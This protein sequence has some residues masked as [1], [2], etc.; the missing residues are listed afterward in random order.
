M[1]IL[2]IYKKYK[3]PHHLQLHILRVGAVATLIIDNI[4]H[5]LVTEFDRNLIITIC[6]LHDMGNVIK[7]DFSNGSNG[8]SQ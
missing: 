3:I 5:E 1:T 4:N 7:F 6:L 2:E 8:F